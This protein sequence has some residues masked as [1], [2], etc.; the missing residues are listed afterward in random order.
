M[1]WR[2]RSERTERSRSKGR[3]HRWD[4]TECKFFLI[5]PGPLEGDAGPEDFGEAASLVSLSLCQLALFPSFI[6]KHLVEFYLVV[7]AGLCCRELN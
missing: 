6:P 5:C 4:T 3:K 2:E 7:P 1:C